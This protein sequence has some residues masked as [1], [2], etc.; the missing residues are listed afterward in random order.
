MKTLL[1]S[2]FVAGS[3]QAT[4]LPV[5]DRTPAVKE[6]IETTVGKKCADITEADLSVIKRIAVGG[7]GIKEF[8]VDDF[9][10]LSALE[11]LNIRS[12]PYTELPEG[13]FRDL[14]HL[15]TLVIIGTGLRHYPD[16]YLAFSPD[17]QELYT[18]GNGVRSISESVLERIENAKKLQAMEFD[19]SLQQPEQDRLNRKFPA[20]GGVSLQF[21]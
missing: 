6:F 11:I 9:T 7:K 15:K 18:F 12:N 2:L 19:S 16:D 21:N 4:V 20:G 14:V 13:L 17:I 10:G 5:C 8:K 1:L 3:A